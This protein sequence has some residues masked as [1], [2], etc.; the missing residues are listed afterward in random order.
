MIII[1]TWK[2][3]NQ[4]KI[5]KLESK[6]IKVLFNDEPNTSSPGNSDFQLISTFNGLTLQTK[7]N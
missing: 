4:S 7:W 1:S 2:N 6:N 3:E 5:L